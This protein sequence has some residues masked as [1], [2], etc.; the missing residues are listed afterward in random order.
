MKERTPPGK[1]HS[2]GG[3]PCGCICRVRSGS[4]GAEPDVQPSVSSISGSLGWCG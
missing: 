2:I 3:P 1:S 4:K